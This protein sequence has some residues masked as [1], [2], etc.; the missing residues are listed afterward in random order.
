MVRTHGTWLPEKKNPIKEEIKKD[1][2]EKTFLNEPSL[3]LLRFRL[4]NPKA[5]Q[6][7]NTKKNQPTKQTNKKKRPKKETHKQKLLSSFNISNP[8]IK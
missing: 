1:C 7:T 2:K 8:S 6:S 4:K 3:I 5:Q